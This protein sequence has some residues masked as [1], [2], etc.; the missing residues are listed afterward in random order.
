MRWGLSDMTQASNIPA[1]TIDVV[2]GEGIRPCLPELARLRIGV[3]RD[4]PYCYAGT[5]EYER[6][7]LETYARSPRSVFVLVR[8]GGTVV[9]ASSGIPL[10]DE[11][12]AIRE[13]FEAANVA[14][15]DVFYFGESVLLHRW[16]GLGIGH[17]FFDEREAF[18]RGHGFPITAFCSVHRDPGDPRCPP[19]YRPNDAFW[20]K[21]GYTR[22]PA[23]RCRLSWTELG[24]QDE[25][26][27]ELVF[28]T[29]DWRLVR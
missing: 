3:F 24:A 5:E 15:D 19:G 18:A 12:V 14:I 4:W 7:Y 6:R 13:P 2:H 22:N 11:E 21:R 23:M 26:E 8:D 17:R 25:S 29:R 28:W 20:L 1:A 27:H 9:G 16:R 10:V